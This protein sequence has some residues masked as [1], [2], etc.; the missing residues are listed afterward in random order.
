MKKI[1]LHK[2]AAYK[3]LVFDDTN[4]RQR[5]RRFCRYMQKKLPEYYDGVVADRTVRLKFDKYKPKNE[6]EIQDAFLLNKNHAD[7]VIEHLKRLI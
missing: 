7:N 4:T 5:F 3:D 6:D 2:Y 1:S